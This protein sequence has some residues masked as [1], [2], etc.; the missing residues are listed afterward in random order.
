MQA[1][2]EGLIGKIR[3]PKPTCMSRITATVSPTV[4]V[5]SCS[6]PLA[7]LLFRR[8]QRAL[9]TVVDERRMPVPQPKM[10]ITAEVGGQANVDKLLRLQRDFRSES[11]GPRTRWE[12]TQGGEGGR[13]DRD[14]ADG[15]GDTMTMPS[16]AQLLSGLQASRGDD[17]YGEDPTTTALEERIA[18]MAGKEAA[19]FVSSGTMGN[20][21]LSS[22][23]QMVGGADTDVQSSLFGHT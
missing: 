2:T 12:P 3:T 5:A 9:A 11:A 10:E 22:G 14:R 15:A 16:D 4:K 17:V 7:P 13:R 23:R 1:P 8:P 18:R 19:L 6:R 20:R 21:Q